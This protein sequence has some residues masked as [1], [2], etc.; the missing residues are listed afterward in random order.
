MPHEVLTAYLER[1]E[2]AIACL[3]NVYIERYEEEIITPLRANLRIRIR[4]TSGRLLEVNE[5]VCIEEGRLR[6]LDYRYHCQDVS[7]KLL[8]R[9]DSTPH[10]PALT[11][12]PHHKHLLNKVI[13]VEK[14][15]ILTIL[16]EATKPF[17]AYKS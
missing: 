14:P 16:E 3:P 4:F 5:A 8:F 11:Q 9:Y 17:P 1:I 2:S 13:G 7:A 15:D 12:F 10:F 6:H